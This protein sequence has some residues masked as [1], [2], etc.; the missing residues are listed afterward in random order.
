MAK[1]HLGW[2]IAPLWW[3]MAPGWTGA[4]EVLLLNGAE[5]R[6]PLL[7]LDASA[8]KM[9]TE[10]G[11]ELSFK[12]DEVLFVKFRDGM[13]PVPAN[14]PALRVRLVDGSMLVCQGVGLIGSQAEL[15]LFGGQ[16]LSLPLA[17]LSAVL[18]E[19]QVAKSIEEFDAL[20]ASKPRVDVVKLLSRD[21]KSVNTF[22]G[23]LGDADATGETIRF[24]PEGG[25]AT[26]LSLARVRA[27]WFSRPPLNQPA[28]IGWARDLYQ[29]RFAIASVELA[30]DTLRFKT[31][32]G[33][34][35]AMAESKIADLDL[36]IGK[37]VYLSDL[38][39]VAVETGSVWVDIWR[40]RW[41]RD[42][43]LTGAPLTLGQRSF[44]K[45][46]ALQA[47]TVLEFDVAGYNIFRGV[48]GIDNQFSVGRAV[49]TIQADG[50]ELLTLPVR[51][52]A[53][54]PPEVELKITGTKR[55]KIIVDYGPDMDLGAHVILGDA[56]V[57][58]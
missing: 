15:R 2:L 27:L 53:D 17:S 24:T 55:L 20:V 29:N 9:R 45:G 22:E 34:T 51:A 7:H 33:L 56:R 8:L 10:S 42:R 16:R 40:K 47:R 46:L 5:H 43:N 36:S 25:D 38:D 6:G 52:R 23:A 11:D 14:V 41:R 58:R 49:I 57:L 28:T 18:C 54:A 21:G 44:A 31:P 19:A 39:P 30:G 13:R 1:T 35:L 50:K 26:Q 4:S 3:L 37:Q 32:T 48:A 12:L